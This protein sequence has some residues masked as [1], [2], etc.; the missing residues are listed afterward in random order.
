MRVDSS[1]RCFTCVI[2]A[3][4]NLQR[5]WLW[6]K[7]ARDPRRRITDVLCCARNP[8]PT[9]PTDAWAVQQRAS[10]S[11]DQRVRQRAAPSCSQPLRRALLGQRCHTHPNAGCDTTLRGPPAPTMGRVARKPALFVAV[12]VVAALVASSMPAADAAKS[13]TNQLSM[14]EGGEVF[15]KGHY[16]EVRACGR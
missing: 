1:G 13:W 5:S 2:A 15:L 7:H 8:T 14:K 9:A 6:A 4:Q 3:Q 16:I 10:T 12:L 11:V